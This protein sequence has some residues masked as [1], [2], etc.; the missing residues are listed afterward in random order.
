[1]G[2]VHDLLLARGKE[3]AL[4]SDI[5]RDVVEAA[6]LYMAHEDSPLSVAYSGWAQCALPHRRTP[7]DQ[8]WVVESDHVRLVVE[9]GHRGSG[10]D[11]RGA[12]MPVGV[13]FGSYARLILL[14]L[15]TEAIRTHSREVELGGSWRRWMDK[16]GISW[17]GS[18]GKAVREQA[19]RLARCRL[20]FHLQGQG[21]A[22][23][24]NQN[25]LDRADWAELLEDTGTSKGRQGRLSLETAKLSEGFFE[26]LLKHP[27]PLEESAIK[28]LANNS[29]ALDTYIWLA[30]RLHSLRS[31]KLVRWAALKAQFGASYKEAYHFKARFPTLLQLATAV[32]PEAKLEV[33]DEGVLLKPSRP[34]VA[35][36]HLRL[37]TPQ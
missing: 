31:P 20:T 14:Y 37:G 29:A 25:I 19:E 3:A 4:A 12:M 10:K 6:A 13:P 21:R 2:E 36:R 28:G 18:S 23:L 34:P 15:Q 32:Y 35:P 24:V 11:G 17:G 33:L 9:P 16:I 22:A 27:V 8:L 30:Y 1:M 26:Q 5:P 7:S